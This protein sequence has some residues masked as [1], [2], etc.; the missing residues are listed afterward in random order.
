MSKGF[1]LIEIMIAILVL[2]V[3]IV[4]IYALLPKIVLTFSVNTNRFIATQ[5]AREGLELIRNIRDSNW[6]AGAEWSQNLTICSSGCEIDYNDSEPII[7]QDRFLRI[8]S[9][10]FYNYE[11]GEPTKFKRK[12]TIIQP[13]ADLLEVE[14][15]VS[16]A[17]RYSPFKV[18][19][20]LYNW[21]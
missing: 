6:L 12:I 2:S 9:N 3:G 8:D 11:S 4:G 14:V 18:Q 5:L 17:G 1:T 16:W 13:Q 15:E 20:K 7:F 10:G 21:R 19:E